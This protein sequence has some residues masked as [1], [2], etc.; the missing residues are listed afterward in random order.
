MVCCEIITMPLLFTWIC[1]ISN[2]QLFNTFRFSFRIDLC[3][4]SFSS[5]CETFHI[6]FFSLH[7]HS[8]V[9][10]C[11][12]IQAIQYNL[13]FNFMPV[14]SA[15]VYSAQ[16]ILLHFMIFYPPFPTSPHPSP[17]AS[18]TTKHNMVLILFS[19]ICTQ[20]VPLGWEL[21]HSTYMGNI[22]K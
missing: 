15:Y 1:N 12:A 5:L 8:R 6:P 4:L 16:S 22:I 3:L 18:T 10:G 13:L 11:N 20:A 19:C 9:S 21:K 7:F 2:I 14:Y 17:P